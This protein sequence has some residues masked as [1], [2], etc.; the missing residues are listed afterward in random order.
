MSIGK[1]HAA[2]GQSIQVWCRGLRVTAKTPAP[3]IQI[4]DGYKHDVGAICSANR[5][6]EQNK[7][8]E[9][10]E[11]IFDCYGDERKSHLEISQ[12]LKHS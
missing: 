2:V 12:S 10:T 11:N 9:Q 7:E 5:I 8:S 6:D 1:K 4:I 3:I